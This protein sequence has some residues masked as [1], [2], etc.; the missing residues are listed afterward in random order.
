MPSGVFYAQDESSWT[1][2]TR[3]PVVLNPKKTAR[4]SKEEIAVHIGISA[5]AVR[6]DARDG[7]LDMDDFFSAAEYTVYMKQV[8]QMRKGD[9]S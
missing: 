1:L 7:V 6:R 2:N 5:D 4:V 8:Q 3:I 9:A